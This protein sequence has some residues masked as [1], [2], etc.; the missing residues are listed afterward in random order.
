MVNIA[1]SRV[2]SIISG[3]ISGDAIIDKSIKVFPDLRPAQLEIVSL[4]ICYE[5]SLHWDIKVRNPSPQV[6]F[7]K[8][9]VINVYDYTVLVNRCVRSAP[10]SISA[11]YEALLPLRK[12]TVK[13]PISQ[14][15]KPNDVDRFLVKLAAD[16]NYTSGIT[17]M[18]LDFEIVYNEDNRKTRGRKM[19]FSVPASK[20]P[21]VYTQ[22]SD[23]ASDR[24]RQLMVKEAK[25]G[26]KFL[27][28]YR[29]L[30]IF[31]SHESIRKSFE[32]FCKAFAGS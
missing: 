24:D 5:D 4:D 21:I 6:V 14:A 10:I 27:E 17:L 25:N 28:E 20:Q 9:F 26:L 15:I 22:L 8:E 13:I 7:A 18:V 30:E 3:K 1:E 11:V 32:S 2:D 31:P 29:N 16:V 23:F 12:G 19:L